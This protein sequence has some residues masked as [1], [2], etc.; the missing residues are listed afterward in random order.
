M[1]EILGTVFGLFAISV[2]LRLVRRP[3]GLHAIPAII[4]THASHRARGPNT[5][6]PQGSRTNHNISLVI[7]PLCDSLPMACIAIGRPHEAVSLTWRQK[8]WQPFPPHFAIS[9]I[10]RPVGRPY[11]LHDIPA[12]IQTHASHKARGP[13]TGEP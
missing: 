13:K 10:L 3:Y 8:F 5:C 6:E 11:G 4:Q 2:I 1:R 7:D 9:A 12:I